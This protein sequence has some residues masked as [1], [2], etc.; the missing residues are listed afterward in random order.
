MRSAADAIARRSVRRRATSRSL[1][2]NLVALPPKCTPD[3]MSLDTPQTRS[4]G[5]C[6]FCVYG[7]PALPTKFIFSKRTLEAPP[8]G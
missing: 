5:F 8:R 7:A 1:A 6:R 2:A 3:E 4:R